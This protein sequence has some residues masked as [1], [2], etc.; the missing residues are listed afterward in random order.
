MLLDDSSNVVICGYVASAGA[1]TDYC[2]LKFNSSG[3]QKWVRTY[4]GPSSNFDIATGLALDDSGYIYVNGTSTGNFNA[5]YY[6]IK[7]DRNGSVKWGARYNHNIAADQGSGVAVDQ[8]GNVYAFGESMSGST[9]ESFDWA[10][11]KY[12]SLGVRQ[13]VRRYDGPASD[14]DEAD[15]VIVDNA[16]NIYL[17]GASMGI[18]TDLDY[19]LLKYDTSGNLIWEQRY[20]GTGNGFD[21]P[22]SIVLDESENLYLTGNSTGSGGNLDMLTIK[23][24]QSTGIQ[25]I[26]ENIPVN[27]SL[28]QN[29]PN[30]FN[31]STKIRFE[32]P[33]ES[34]GQTV[35]IT[36]W[37]SVGKQ[38]SEL[39]NQKLS[40]GIYEI[41]FDGTDLAGGVYFYRLQAAETVLTRKMVMIK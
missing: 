7:Y 24:S 12:N 4:N 21:F 27:F 29:Y 23:Y 10:L 3:D 1:F 41:E 32:I 6:T 30:P 36:V 37:N 31:P 28:Q 19:L 39:I 26:S 38:V 11:V 16:G 13:W 2:V 5:D 34:A 9:F 18:N 20:D 35:R 33:K 14:F 25:T 8:N 17:M 40:A 22:A 15:D